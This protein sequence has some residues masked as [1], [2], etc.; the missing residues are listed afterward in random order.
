MA[1]PSVG[2]ESHE[3]KPGMA[4]PPTTSPSEFRC[5][6]NVSGTSLVVSGTS[7]MAANFIGW[8]L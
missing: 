3:A 4:M 6:N 8:L 7:S 2:S 1:V 5:P